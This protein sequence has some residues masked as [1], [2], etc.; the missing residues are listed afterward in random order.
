MQEVIKTILLYNVAVAMRRCLLAAGEKTAGTLLGQG[1]GWRRYHKT[2]AP[3]R[4]S[5]ISADGVED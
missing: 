2:M 3:W 5:T 1:G 4:V